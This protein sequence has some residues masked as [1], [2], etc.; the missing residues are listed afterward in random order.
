VPVYVPS[1]PNDGGLTVGALWSFLPPP[2]VAP[3]QYLGFQLW[4][5]HLLHRVTIERRAVRLNSSLEVADILAG[6]NEKGLRP[7]VAVVR[8]RQEFGP[9][10]LGH[11]SLLAVPD[12][13]EVK[14]RLNRVKARQWYRPVA[15]MIAVEALEEVFGRPCLSPYMDKAPAVKPEMIHRY[16]ALAHLDGTARH[17]S[18]SRSDEPW[19]HMLLT[20]VGKRTGLAA[21]INTS[22]NTKGEPLVNT[23][24]ASLEMLDTLPDL[25]A[26]VIEDWLFTKSLKSLKPHSQR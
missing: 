24:T 11:R 19:L 8:G 5:K 22:F 20:A 25:D 23:I 10:A 14:D 17:Q 2:A 18:V 7:I 1:N 3:L 16:P 26:V 21:L 6:T 15:P 13:E 4:D 12:S 9:R